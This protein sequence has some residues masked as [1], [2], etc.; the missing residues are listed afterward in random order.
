MAMMLAHRAKPAAFFPDFIAKKSR[1]G[2]RF[3]SGR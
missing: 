2:Q 1:L 3:L